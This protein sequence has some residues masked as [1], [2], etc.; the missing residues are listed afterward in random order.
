MTSAVAITLEISRNMA[1]TTCIEDGK[2]ITKIRYIQGSN[3]AG[4]KYNTPKEDN[5]P[6]FLNVPN[7]EVQVSIHEENKHSLSKII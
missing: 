3:N 1:L 4:K 2:G 5:Y 7:Q 6:I